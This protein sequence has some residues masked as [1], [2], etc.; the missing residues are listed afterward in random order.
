MREVHWS[1][2]RLWSGRGT[3]IQQ[4]G[5]LL[6]WV[7]AN[8]AAWGL[9]APLGHSFARAVGAPITEAWDV[10]LAYLLTSDTAVAGL[11]G[12]TPSGGA[13]FGITIG[14][15]F[16]ALIGVAQASVL[17]RQLSRP[18]L[19][20]AATLIGWSLTFF[21]ASLANKLM[22]TGVG[23]PMGWIE[24]GTVGGLIDG[25]VVGALAGIWQWAV[26]RL[27]WSWP[28]TSARRLTAGPRSTPGFAPAA[29]D[30]RP[31]WSSA[32]AAA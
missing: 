3:P 28:G 11:A 24:R 30:A 15:V 27:C 9:A 22:G 20:I 5:F 8:A 19:W 10:F 7:L 6:V 25:V 26:L 12:G 18:M 17:R 4:P 32:S 13:L 21:A 2:N 29:A 23:F 14:V 16:G 1:S 31:F